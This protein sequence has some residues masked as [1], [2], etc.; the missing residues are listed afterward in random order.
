MT[1]IRVGSETYSLI[2]SV[3]NAALNDLYAL[4]VQTR[5]DGSPGVSVKSISETFTRIGEASAADGFQ[6]I[7]LLD[8]DVFIQNL[9]GLA[10]LARRKAGEHVTFEDAGQIAFND[11]EIVSDDDD[12]D[13][14]APLEEAA[15]SDLPV[16]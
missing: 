5:R 4:K 14:P 2:E 7:D 13:D 8:D 12:E 16:S 9:I 15:E 11:I 6:S 3:N 10:F 1:S